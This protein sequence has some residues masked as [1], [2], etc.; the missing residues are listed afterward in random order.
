MI[1]SHTHKFILLKSLKTAGTSI[2]AALSQACGG[3]DVVTPSTT[4]P[5]T[6]MKQALRCIGR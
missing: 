1:I 4:S 6:A 2:E 3:Q 5:S